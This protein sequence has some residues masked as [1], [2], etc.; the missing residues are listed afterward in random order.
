MANYRKIC[1][2]CSNSFF[3]W[4]SMCFHGFP[5]V[6]NG[7]FMVFYGCS[8]V[9]YGFFKELDS[10]ELEIHRSSLMDT[11]NEYQWKSINEYQWISIN[12]FIDGPSMNMV[13]F[14]WALLWASIGPPLG[15]MGP[16]PQSPQPVWTWLRG[17]SESLGR[18]L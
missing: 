14:L 10:N 4:F 9:F 15:P 2:F 1:L 12:N 5:M 16:G 7:F 3:I 8:M 17:R 18:A 13:F 11:I 6:F